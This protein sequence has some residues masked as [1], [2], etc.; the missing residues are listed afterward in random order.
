MTQQANDPSVTLNVP[1]SLVNYVLNV[2][3]E[4]PHKESR[5][6]I[7]TLTEQAQAALNPPA[8]ID[9]RAADQTGN[10]RIGG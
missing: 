7:D 8:V 3:N 6:A 9:S 4:R 1:L 5:G 2:L 10:E